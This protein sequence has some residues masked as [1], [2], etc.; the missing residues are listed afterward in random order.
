MD[1]E[2]IGINIGHPQK[3]C[4]VIPVAVVSDFPLAGK[5]MNLVFLSLGFGRIG[6]D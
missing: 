5:A 3:T 4:L 2:R 1:D 6:Y